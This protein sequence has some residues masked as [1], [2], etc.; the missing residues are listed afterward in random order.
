MTNRWIH[1]TGMY[2]VDASAS[3]AIV[4]HK[5]K[6]PESYEKNQHRA[7]RLCLENLA[8]ELIKPCIKWRKEIRQKNNFS[9][10]QKSILN[11]IIKTGESINNI[12]RPI[13]NNERLEN[14]KYC[15]LCTGSNRLKSNIA[16]LKC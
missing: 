8:V 5:L 1:N 12:I 6:F 16:C 13:E 9:G 14:R 3:N 15:G 10:I 2:I 11:S 4:L 7:R